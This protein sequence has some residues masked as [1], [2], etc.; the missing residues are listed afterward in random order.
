VGILEVAVLPLLETIKLAPLVFTVTA[1]FLLE[2]TRSCCSVLSTPLADSLVVVKGRVTVFPVA[3]WL[4]VNWISSTL[5]SC[6]WTVWVAAEE[7]LAVFCAFAV[8]VMARKEAAARM[9][10]FIKKVF[11]SCLCFVCLMM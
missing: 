3:E 9:N 11:L 8:A 2:R 10:F 5:L 4:A 6:S 7:A 1:N